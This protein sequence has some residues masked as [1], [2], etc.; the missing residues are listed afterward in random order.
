[1]KEPEYT[2]IHDRPAIWRGDSLESLSII[3]EYEDGGKIIPERV[4]AQIRD[5]FGGLIYEYSPT[6]DLV[7]GEVILEMLNKEVVSKF[8][9]G[10][11]HYDVEYIMSDGLSRTYVKGE[12]PVFED[13]SRC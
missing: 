7:S 5:S 1:M 6:I 2:I 11:Y 10:N 13:S 4:C 8:R 3:L 12:I 9:M